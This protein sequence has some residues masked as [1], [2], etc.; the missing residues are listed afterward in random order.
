MQ[1]AIVYFVSWVIA[2]AASAT[3]APFV[4]DLL[5][6]IP[7]A[8]YVPYRSRS[9]IVQLVERAKMSLESKYD[10]DIKDILYRA[11]KDL[12]TFDENKRIRLR[13]TVI[14]AGLTIL[15]S[16]TLY[17]CIAVGTYLIGQ[18]K[19]EVRTSQTHQTNCYYD[20]P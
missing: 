11:E 14:Q 19:P 18:D 10:Y 3:L 2:I 17:S 8:T 16:I 20:A 7:D 5:W 13:K 15:F 1:L 9:S 6:N 4:A 12:K